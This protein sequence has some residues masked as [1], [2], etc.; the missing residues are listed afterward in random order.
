M[1]TL[2]STEARKLAI[3]LTKS[4]FIGLVPPKHK[5]VGLPYESYQ[6]EKPRKWAPF[7]P[8]MELW[9]TSVKEVTV[10][11]LNFIFSRDT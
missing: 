2:A 6:V 7:K 1:H 4:V 11:A 10:D 5:N 9:E 8:I 3:W